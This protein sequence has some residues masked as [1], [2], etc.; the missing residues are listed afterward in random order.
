M[1]EVLVLGAQ[2]LADERLG[3]DRERVEGE[4]DRGEHVN[5]IWKPA[6]SRGRGSVATTTVASRAI[7]QRHRAQEQPAAGARRAAHS[8]ALWAYRAPTPAGESADDDEV[9][10]DHAPLRD[11]GAVADPAI[12]SRAP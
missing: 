7:A 2:T 3:G 5:A 9:D 1:H 10:G 6:S 11:D 12:P 8:R 4:G